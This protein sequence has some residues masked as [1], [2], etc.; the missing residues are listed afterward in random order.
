MI[1]TSLPLAAIVAA[2]A[3]AS[4]E[5]VASGNVMPV[6]TPAHA[7]TVDMIPEI[8]VTFPGADDE[9]VIVDEAKPITITDGTVIHSGVL[10][11]WGAQRFIVFDDGIDITADG[12]WTL[13]LPA[14]TFTVNGAPV[15]AIE[16]VYTID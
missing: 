12:T 5:A 8:H 10:Y 3:L 2:A 9:K 16:A 4:P 14:G 13:T 7:S 15:G 6:L 11:G 1:H